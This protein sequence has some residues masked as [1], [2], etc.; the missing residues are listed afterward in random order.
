[1]RGLDAG[2]D[3]YLVKPFVEEELRRACAR[4]CGA[5]RCRSARRSSRRPRRRS[6]RA[7]RRRGTGSP[8]GAT[9]FRLLEYLAMNAGLALSRRQILDHVWG[10]DFDGSSNVVDVYVST[11]RRKLAAVGA[12]DASRRSGE[13]ATHFTRSRAAVRV[14][15]AILSCSGGSR[16]RGV[17]LTWPCRARRAR[18]AARVVRKAAAAYAAVMRRIALR[19]AL[20]DVPLVLVAGGASYA[21][22]AL[23]VR[24]LVAAREREARFA[25]EAAHELRTPLARIAARRAGRE[26]AGIPPPRDAAL[27]AQSRRWPSTRRRR[28]ATSSR[29]VREEHVRPASPSPSIWARCAR[30]AAA[31]PR[32][33]V[34]YDVDWTK[35][36]LGRGRRAAAPASRRE[37]A[38]Q[39]CPPRAFHVRLRVARRAAA[40]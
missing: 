32:V 39:R 20:L 13:S 11:V 21:L 36:V 14:V 18:A 27:D 15:S 28:S 29:V 8:F 7:L 1:M 25:A 40:G 35:A 4:C 16:R 30:V 33:G 38:R 10:D 24:P 5:P 37:S 3:D 9:E 6:R 19:L 26:L 12:K 23:S 22:A 34:R 17:R 31:S 2:A